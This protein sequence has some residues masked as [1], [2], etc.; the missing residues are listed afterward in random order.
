[1]AALETVI[2]RFTHACEACEVAFVR[3]PESA[4]PDGPL[5]TVA[6]ARLHDRV[7]SLVREETPTEGPV[8]PH[9]CLPIERE[10]VRVQPWIERD[11]CVVRK[12]DQNFLS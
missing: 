9:P 3:L 5:E 6:V 7:S 4:A 8:S 10:H 2:H 11:E 1:M 12:C